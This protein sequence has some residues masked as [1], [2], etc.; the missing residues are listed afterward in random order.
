MDRLLAPTIVH[1]TTGL[2][3]LA[4]SDDFLNGHGEGFALGRRFG[5]YGQRLRRKVSHRMAWRNAL[6]F[7]WSAFLFPFATIFFLKGKNLFLFQRLI[8][9][10]MDRLR[11]KIFKGIMTVFAEG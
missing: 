8:T 2:A 4:F 9:R 1:H 5:C 10:F 6:P 11:V 7:S 3:D